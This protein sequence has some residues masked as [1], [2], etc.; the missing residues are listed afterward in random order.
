M[1]GQDVTMSDSILTSLKKQLNIGEDL[2]AFDSDLILL[3]NTALSALNQMGVGPENGFQIKDES[4]TWDMFID[5]PRLNMVFQEIYL[6]VRLAFD[7]P[8]G[9]VLSSMEA[10]LK[11]LDWRL[12]VASEE[13]SKHA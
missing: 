11:E 9:S 4:E 10:T 8:N 12:T 7:P 1:A 13:V 3:I 5:D 2:S 6:R